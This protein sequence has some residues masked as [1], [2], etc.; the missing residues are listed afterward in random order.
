MLYDPNAGPEV[1]A[2]SWATAAGNEGLHSGSHTQAVD[3]TGMA[4]HSRGRSEAHAAQHAHVL[5]IIFAAK[6]V[7]NPARTQQRTI[8]H[9]DRR[10]IGHRKGPLPPKP[11][12]CEPLRR[13]GG[14]QAFPMLWP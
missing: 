1:N 6:G 8:C 7:F 5:V 3:T 14:P 2:A 11:H 13:V 12:Q 9:D 10:R 4:M